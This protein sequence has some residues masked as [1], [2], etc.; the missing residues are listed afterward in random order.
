[1][2]DR[3]VYLTKL[4]KSNDR[5]EVL[6]HFS[7]RRTAPP[8]SRSFNSLI[9]TE[10]VSPSLIHLSSLCLASIASVLTKKRR[11]LNVQRR[12]VTIGWKGWKNR[13]RNEVEGGFSPRKKWGPR[14][15]GVGCRGVTTS[16]LDVCTRTGPKEK[17]IRVQKEWKYKSRLW[18]AIDYR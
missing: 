5:Q 7:Q 9:N 13:R 6:I 14:G 8:R 15:C 10:L 18:R 3:A 11:I 1:M 16:K 4:M 2:S 12:R 17:N